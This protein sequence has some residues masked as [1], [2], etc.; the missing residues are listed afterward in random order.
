MKFFT[1]SIVWTV[2]VA[3]LVNTV[4]PSQAH[5]DVGFLP[6]PGKMVSL[7]QPFSPLL[8]RGIKIHKDNPF[9]FD[10][11]VDTGDTGSVPGSSVLR[12]EGKKLAAYFF[13]SL[14]I[15][16]KD[17]WVNLSP[18]E[19]DRT[20]DRHFGNTE[21]G[22][23][24]LAQDYV[25]KQVT[26]SVMYPEGEVGKKFWKHIYAEAF[27][28]FGTTNI[29][30]DFMNK[31]WLVPDKA[32][33]FENAADNTVMVIESTLKVMLEEDYLAQQKNKIVRQAQGVSEDHRKL[34]SDMIR[35][36]IVP[37]LE[38]EVNTGS[39]FAPLRQV[40]NSLIL[41][42]WF[43]DHL[44]SSLLGRAYVD[45][46]KTLGVDVEDK[47]INEQIYQQYLKAFRKGVYNYIKEEIDPV[48]NEVV[49]RKYFSG[50][51]T[52]G[53]IRVETVKGVDGAQRA[54]RKINPARTLIMSIGLAAA[55]TGA[56]LLGSSGAAAANYHDNNP[57]AVSAATVQSGDIALRI[58]GNAPLIKKY[59][60]VTK[61]KFDYGDF[62]NLAKSGAISLQDAKGEPIK[63]PN[64][65]KIYP[66]Q[67]VNFDLTLFAGAAVE[68]ASGTAVG[69]GSP[70]PPDDHKHPHSHGPEKP[71]AKQ[72]A[73]KIA[74]VK[75]TPSGPVTAADLKLSVQDGWTAAGLKILPELNQQAAP[76]SLKELQRL[77]N[78]ALAD[79]LEAFRQWLKE[80]GKGDFKITNGIRTAAYSQSMIERG[81][82]AEPGGC[83]E[84]GLCAD[85]LPIGMSQADLHQY[86]VQFG[87]ENPDHG[88]HSHLKVTEAQIQS[89]K[90][91]LEINQAIAKLQQN[92]SKTKQALADNPRQIAAVQADIERTNE[93]R[94]KAEAT[95][96]EQAQDREPDTPAIE[97]PPDVIPSPSSLTLAT[98]MTSD[99]YVE[100]YVAAQLAKQRAIASQPV[101][102]QSPI[103][104]RTNFSYNQTDF[105][106]GVSAKGFS[107]SLVPNVPLRNFVELA[108]V[109]QGFA[110]F[111]SLSTLN[112]VGGP[113]VAG[114]ILLQLRNYMELYPTRGQ[115][116][117]YDTRK[118]FFEALAHTLLISVTPYSSHDQQ[119][120]PV[121][122]N[123]YDVGLFQLTQAVFGAIDRGLG[124]TG[125]IGNGNTAFPF[126]DNGF[127][128]AIGNYHKAFDYQAAVNTDPN[129]I[130]VKM[131][132]VVDPQTRYR[133]NSKS[134]WD[135]L[136][137]N[138]SPA[139]PRQD[140][141]AAHMVGFKLQFDPRTN[142][143]SGQQVFAEPSFITD[144]YAKQL[145][146]RAG[147]NGG[148][149]LPEYRPSIADLQK[150]AMLARGRDAQGNIIL[151][152][153]RSSITNR[154]VKLVT[155]GREL[156]AM[157]SVA[158]QKGNLV[159]F[160]PGPSA[161]MPEGNMVGDYISDQFRDFFRS[162]ESLFRTRT[163]ADEYSG[164]YLATR[165]QAQSMPAGLSSSD[166]LIF[167]PGPTMQAIQKNGDKHSGV[168]YFF[169]GRLPAALGDNTAN[170]QRLLS[171]LGAANGVRAAGNG[172]YSIQGYPRPVNGKAMVLLETNGQVA[173]IIDP[174]NKVR[175]DRIAQLQSE[176]AA[177]NLRI[178]G[179]SKYGIVYDHNMRQKAVTNRAGLNEFIPAQY[180]GV[181]GQ[182]F[183]SK[184]VKI[185]EK[186]MVKVVNGK[187]VAMLDPGYQAMLERKT[188]LEALAEGGLEVED[189]RTGKMLYFAKGNDLTDKQKLLGLLPE[190]IL[191]D[192]I[193]KGQV[194]MVPVAGSDKQRFIIL[195]EPKPSRFEEL[196]R[197]YPQRA[198]LAS[199]EG[200]QQIQAPSSTRAAMAGSDIRPA[201]AGATPTVLG[202]DNKPFHGLTID[203]QTFSAD[204]DIPKLKDLNANA[205]RAYYPIPI[206]LA[207]R[208]AKES[209][210]RTM[211]VS[212]PLNHYA[213]GQENLTKFWGGA[214]PGVADRISLQ[215]NNYVPYIKNL[216]E[217]MQQLG[218]KVTIELLN[219]PNE[220]AH[221]PVWVNKP[222]TEAT[223]KELFGLIDRHARNIHAQF[224]K[225]VTVSTTI[226]DRPEHYV[227]ALKTDVDTVGINYYRHNDSL[228]GDLERAYRQAGVKKPVYLAETG[229]NSSNGVAHQSTRLRMDLRAIEKM[230]LSATLMSLDDNPMK[231]GD[232][233]AHW[234]VTGKPAYD[235]IKSVWNTQPAPAPEAAPAPAPASAP[236]AKVT[237]MT[238]MNE[239][240]ALVRWKSDN[241]EK[242]VTEESK[243]KNL[244]SDRL[245]PQ[246]LDE[247]ADIIMREAAEILHIGPTG[248]TVGRYVKVFGGGFEL[249]K[250][251]DI[252][253]N[254]KIHA[255]VLRQDGRSEFVSL[256]QLRN[257]RTKEQVRRL[258]DGVELR[259]KDDNVA[260]RV[261][262]NP[263][264]EGSM[265]EILGPNETSKIFELL[266]YPSS[267]AVAETR[268]FTDAQGRL[269]VITSH[270][271]GVNKGIVVE[272]VYKKVPNAKPQMLYSVRALQQEVI[273][274]GSDG[275][276]RYSVSTDTVKEPGLT[277]TIDGK[278][279][280]HVTG[281]YSFDK[282][283][284]AGFHV[285]LRDI[286]KK[287]WLALVRRSVFANDQLQNDQNG[288]V[289]LSPQLSSYEEVMALV[290]QN[291]V[292]TRQDA[293]T[294]TDEGRV[295]KRQVTNRT[296][297]GQWHDAW[298]IQGGKNMT[299]PQLISQLMQNPV[300]A[301]ALRRLGVDE[302]TVLSE[303]FTE[304]Q[305]G[306]KTVDYRVLYDIRERKII[307]LTLEGNKNFNIK[308]G[309]S[310][311]DRTGEQDLSYNLTP[312]MQITFLSRTVPNDKP[313]RQTLPSTVAEK[314]AQLA[315]KYFNIEGADFWADAKLLGVSPDYVPDKV[316]IIPYLIKTDKPDLQGY[317]RIAGKVRELIRQYSDSDD[318][319]VRDEILEQITD[320]VRAHNQGKAHYTDVPG[321]PSYRYLL[322]HDPS[323]R[324]FAVELANGNIEVFFPWLE[325]RQVQLTN[326]GRTSTVLLPPNSNPGSMILNSMGEVQKSMVFDHSKNKVFRSA[327]GTT[328]TMRLDYYTILES[329]LEKTSGFTAGAQHVFDQQ[330][331]V[332]NRP[333]NGLLGVQTRG[334]VMAVY[335][336]DSPVPLPVYG[337]L[338]DEGN[339]I[340][341]VL[342]NQTFYI[343]GDEQI[344]TS[345]SLEAEPT[346]MGVLKEQS[347]EI[348]DGKPVDGTKR[349]E[350]VFTTWW[351]DI[352]N[353]LKVFLVLPGLFTVVFSLG[354]ILKERRFKA[355]QKKLDEK[356]D[357][358]ADVP[359]P[360]PK[361]E[362]PLPS[363]NSY[364]FPSGVVDE[365]R[366]TFY[367][368][369][370]PRL[371]DGE[372]LETVLKQH[373]EAYQVWR[374]YFKTYPAGEEPAEFVPTLEDL[375][376]QTLI[377][378][379]SEI[380]R[381][382]MPDGLAYLFDK[383]VEAKEKRL[384]TGF[385]G[386][387]EKEYTRWHTI[388]EI[389]QTTFQGL[390]G[391]N[392]KHVVPYDF[393]FR[394]EDLN[395]MFRNK[396]KI[397]WYDNLGYTIDGKK[398]ARDAIY[399]D[400]TKSL[401]QKVAALMNA[402]EGL[403]SKFNKNIFL[404]KRRAPALEEYQDYV[405]F[406]RQ[407]QQGHYELGEKFSF[408]DV[409][410]E[411]AQRRMGAESLMLKTYSDAD[412]WIGRWPLP[413]R[414]VKA[415]A[416]GVR[417][418]YSQ[419]TYSM[420]LSVG[421]GL[422]VAA[423]DGHIQTTTAAIT[424]LTIL[425]VVKLL[426]Y[427]LDWL[428]NRNVNKKGVGETLPPWAGYER[429]KPSTEQKVYRGFFWSLTIGLKVAWDAFLFHYFLIPHMETVGAMFYPTIA[430]VDV[431]VN[432][433][434]LLMAQQ[435]STSAFFLFLS[436]WAS[437]LFVS[438][439]TSYVFGAYRGLGKIRS[440]KDIRM[441][442][443]DGLLDRLID[444]KILPHNG[445]GLDQEQRRKAREA[446]WYLVAT[447]MRSRGEITDAEVEA[448]NEG[449]LDSFAGK[450]IQKRVASFI[451]SL[452]MDSP[453]MPAFEA[454][455][456]ATFLIPVYGE[457]IVYG[458]EPIG[459]DAKTELELE[460][461][462]GY[463]NLNY[464]I[465]IA[466]P[467]W[468]NLIERVE[469]E[470][471][472][473]DDELKRMKE[474]LTRNGKLGEIS[475][476]LKREIRLW[477]TYRGQAFGRTLDGM[478][479][480][481][482]SLQLLARIS[483]PDWTE[484]RIRAEVNKKFQMLW[485]YQ[486]WGDVK[487]GTKPEH[488]M[489]KA[490]TLYLLKKYYD[491]L[492]MD[493]QI[494]SLQH[495]GGYWYK[496]LSHYD[497]N[498][499]EI[500]DIREIK[501]TK[502]RPITLEGKPSNQMHASTFIRNPIAL[503]ID[504]NQDL[505]PEQA[506]KLPLMLQEFNDP[507]VD[508][509]NVP[510]R[511]FTGHFSMAGTFHA[512]MDRTFN[513]SSKRHMGMTLSPFI[514]GHPDAWRTSTV[515][516]HG[517]Y[518]STTSV[519]EDYI[520]GEQLVLR[521]KKII[522]VE[523]MEFDKARE[524]SWTGTDGI[525]RKF[526]MGSAQFLKSRHAY[527][528]NKYYSPVEGAAEFYSGPVFYPMQLLSGISLVLYAINAMIAGISA[529][530]AF[531]AAIVVAMVGVL[532][533]GQ[534]STMHG[535]T[536]MA[537]EDGTWKATIK[538][539]SLWL[540]GGMIPFNIAH[541]FTMST[542]FL[543]GMAGV[544]T[545]NATGRGFN[546]E[547]LP[548]LALATGFGK[549]H[550]L[551]GVSGLLLSAY[552]IGI[553]FNWTFVS[554]TLVILSFLFPA[555]TM[556]FMNSGNMPSRMVPAKHFLK[557]FKDDVVS[558]RNMEF[559]D[560][561]V[562][563]VKIGLFNRSLKDRGD[564]D[565]YLV[566]KFNAKFKKDAARIDEL[567]EHDVIIVLNELLSD[568]KFLSNDFVPKHRPLLP[569]KVQ[570]LL[571][572]ALSPDA[573]LG[574]EQ[575]KLG[576]QSIKKLN[577][578]LLQVMYPEQIVKGR[579]LRRSFIDAP[580]NALVVGV[581]FAT[582]APVALGAYLYLN[583]VKPRDP[584]NGGVM[585]ALQK[586]ATADAAMAVTRPA[587]P[588]APEVL[589]APLPEAAVSAPEPVPVPAVVDK[590]VIAPVDATKGGIDL[591][592]TKVK[593]KSDG[594]GVTTAFDD[595]AMLQIILE[596]DGLRPVIYNVEN[597]TPSMI[598]LLLGLNTHDALPSAAT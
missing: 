430:G 380:Y 293:Y 471:I 474:L 23:E 118:S 560:F 403:A 76:L 199:P 322:P 106:L 410:K 208:M 108:R 296:L 584:P 303:T 562:D 462:V 360:S 122:G 115:T 307:T 32:V 4:A 352:L 116:K 146:T 270:L 89:Y 297:D 395:D 572:I 276:E 221:Y 177:L 250:T 287:N 532:I 408:G 479:N 366:D 163:A 209:P 515:D 588:E 242:S 283:T 188:L 488:V 506:F 224:G 83:H 186:M 271:R 40:Y 502:N 97:R 225:S 356:T 500:E 485:A 378:K 158:D 96:A 369:I 458:Y 275:R 215:A 87:F 417:N 3:F 109:G 320:V 247:H 170:A 105:S 477:A 519:S 34:S 206:E 298:T 111:G 233:E 140:F 428:L 423:L 472:A 413:F 133:K 329:R 459:L 174:S 243:K 193:M 480:Y 414:L 421:T 285:N 256:D 244:R 166:V 507:T 141:R 64:W 483:H 535:Y 127:V 282:I 314:Y 59:E 259:D 545:Y 394:V 268:Q 538:Y 175:Q 564:I 563:K 142:S 114:H 557:L 137:D 117:M 44:K 570:K 171:S 120:Q 326:E 57:T 43:K 353:N 486:I 422:T 447:Q 596:S 159:R 520:G 112:Q 583:L 582:T 439:F 586:T 575:S 571:D 460:M 223:F 213:Y 499:G 16:E 453:D 383:F 74:K 510:E 36:I 187:V 130:F 581:W 58:L 590:A 450:D 332:R 20:I 135:I 396:E 93:D 548:P 461:K 100:G 531:P 348:K 349:E 41:A 254:L 467:Q 25:L 468:N 443:K 470:G 375:W 157:P 279:V 150:E 246:Q 565:R 573:K 433:N 300:I 361:F 191:A 475:D 294:Y 132:R 14:T 229:E 376:V 594:R 184:Q 284:G 456:R 235:I 85:L 151:G 55:L 305:A 509:V 47:T 540:F 541:I 236:A 578:S 39:N 553:W 71:P 119:N 419:L 102:A 431:G 391:G 227:L 370:I 489:K 110:N 290:H 336:Q 546:R 387:V 148:G 346:A 182:K 463:T 508:V 374:K 554:S 301:E 77:M 339:R 544:A 411:E 126:E 526:A 24:V 154:I 68:A 340:T 343:S 530:A 48:S 241:P 390:S 231:K 73:P 22:K 272:D 345:T 7:T 131:Y 451:N 542:G 107:F 465:S 237:S 139:D 512:I 359:L 67:V 415:F 424:G 35:Q 104:G 123:V 412:A 65:N 341:S 481:A 291:S 309:A 82:P 264:N 211:I 505:S 252:E 219:E 516:Q 401:R 333:A 195:K 389:Q 525:I 75:A 449:K 511:I 513:S 497:P 267:N 19:K 70:P 167:D 144:S 128:I 591:A 405:K 318:H 484:E 407:I 62:L 452:L 402:L 379:G 313:I 101:F 251:A 527:W 13:A 310:F 185:T 363:W 88:D 337:L 160:V 455:Q 86:A 38:E 539:W 245:T 503:T 585:A 189:Q 8:L 311:N 92:L 406:F 593:V 260:G 574:T 124:N 368:S 143:M 218:V 558:V 153:L 400:L 258:A 226:S 63:N 212:I 29:P 9:Q 347:V 51:M 482:R 377:H 490:D 580:V 27:R 566:D 496:V 273:Y 568:P 286:K 492:G 457:D 393:Y 94:R 312:D 238:Q 79:R 98:P 328:R 66:N 216:V 129:T 350:G 181:V 52:L 50:G 280:E 597:M 498:T 147:P 577:W 289:Q 269:H 46:N 248:E 524:T 214:V 420:M 324:N 330:A 11:I 194:E 354:R 595:P 355:V 399:E 319:E 579:N 358:G 262:L 567:T 183:G 372:D 69:A 200:G 90:A 362:A 179:L 589:P 381:A 198:E 91:L 281:L 302:T 384:G 26:A 232:G 514:H 12:A 21:M 338:V 203:A 416:H 6:A 134:G 495:K 409:D 551:V 543:S 277:L 176:R 255:L 239:G 28:K 192:L 334:Q 386:F 327:D 274:F 60:E 95:A 441:V 81:Y 444:D 152:A 466:R 178:E 438:A 550:V 522:N 149:Y 325:G 445:R 404:I 113:L 587:K 15:P 278:T 382:N 357:D 197:L 397:A 576:T 388:L 569:K 501:M 201:S 365:A 1:K 33:V 288:F 494:A 427:P 426:Y 321:K 440:P 253:S 559:G 266:S 549:S 168:V 533:V 373:F 72:P 385:G 442:Q 121:S 547:H 342:L 202:P 436:S 196:K 155:D 598:N 240:Y 99:K 308:I 164:D 529:F 478:M 156:N 265:V 448:I 230:G 210:V 398:D 295:E 257:S 534:A 138:S 592:P 521:G 161:P 306:V 518:S 371:E 536:Q 103:T 204:T 49:P 125:V 437:Y 54:A 517:G 476:E 323:G 432:M 172:M 173:G 31:V 364:G 556:F 487:N 165:P 228:T 435:W 561:Y 162:W 42:K 351:D 331:Y 491:E 446:M 316:E 136:E 56:S 45:R 145:S 61:K 17:M 292:L 454:I 344:I 217:V 418:T 434:L 249:W 263:N 5:A 84:Q 78:P 299:Q 220:P 18:Y 304:T 335:D 180:A 222:A 473:T 493:I 205:V 392:A 469:R 169:D 10:F 425:A 261:Y 464:L 80:T 30:V 367:S 528:G 523:Y 315:K 234:G 552:A 37:V 555:V 207:K 53:G 190:S 504:M 2:L 429:Q 537:L 317:K